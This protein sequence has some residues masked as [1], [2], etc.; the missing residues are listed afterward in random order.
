MNYIEYIQQGAGI[1]GA[2]L[3][4]YLLH[5]D[6]VLAFHCSEKI[7]KKVNLE[8]EKFLLAH[9][10]QRFQSVVGWFHFFRPC[11]QGRSCGEQVVKQSFSP[12]SDEEVERGLRVQGQNIP[13]RGTPP[14]TYFR[15]L[16]PITSQ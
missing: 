8:Q 14:V 7:P 11:W 3:E 1:V 16:A 12:Y 10:S 6:P 15:Q 2:V 9:S 13:F 4:F 5:S